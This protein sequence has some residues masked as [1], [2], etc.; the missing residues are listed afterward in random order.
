MGGGAGEMVEQR[1]PLGPELVGDRG[2][3]SRA[4][5]RLHPEAPPQ[6]VHRSDEDREQRAGVV[7]ACTSIRECH[8]TSE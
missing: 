8:S 1:A 4:A 7:R 3:S 6:V 2:R 5:E